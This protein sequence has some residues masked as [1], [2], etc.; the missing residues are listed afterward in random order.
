LKN[1]LKNTKK[2]N[3]NNNND[4]NNEHSNNSNDFENIT[5]QMDKIYLNDTESKY[6]IN[7]IKHLCRNLFTKYLNRK[8]Y[9]S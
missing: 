7:I 1:Y 2:Y 9:F 4:F 6:C 3:Q 5:I 8:I